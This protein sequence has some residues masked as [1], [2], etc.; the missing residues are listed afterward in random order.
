MEILT[1]EM[2]VPGV[3]GHNR[4]TKYIPSL[5]EEET[6]L[7][8]ARINFSDACLPMLTCLSYLPLSIFSTPLLLQASF[9]PHALR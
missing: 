7:Q 9:G 1:L 8:T 3:E 6:G 2:I 4:W 5:A